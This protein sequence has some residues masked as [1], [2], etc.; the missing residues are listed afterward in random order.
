MIPDTAGKAWNYWHELVV[1]EELGHIHGFGLPIAIGVQTH[2]ATPA[3]HEFG[4][5]YPEGNLP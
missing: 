1:M 5:E 4:S 3:I 2:M